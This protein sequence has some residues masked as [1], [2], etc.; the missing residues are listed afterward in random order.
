MPFRIFERLV[1][2]VA[3][4]GTHA[5]R[6][7]GTEVPVAPPP[8]SLAGFYWHFIR[9]A[10]ALFAAL[11]LAGLLVALLDAAIPAMIGR[12][13]ALLTSHAPD[14]LW[15]EAW[16]SLLG[17][18]A[19]VL[20]GRPGAVLLQNLIT[21]QAIN[22]QFHQRWSAGRATGMSSARGWPFFQN[23]F[24]G[25]IA[26][27]VMQSGPAL[28][29]SVVRC[30]NAVWYILVYGS[31]ALLLLAMPTGGWRCPSRCG[32]SP[33]PGCCG[34]LCRGCA[35][36][37]AQCS[38]SALAADRADCGQLHQYPDGEAVRPGGDEDAFVR[39]G[40]SSLT[41]P[42]AGRCGW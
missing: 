19:L 24:A 32:S 29:E 16:P 10:K 40:I 13:V 2:P 39:D 21:K 25:R 3:A 23:D 41:P 11:F 7:F 20:F 15:A 42:S 33:M 30:V 34:C 9:Q 14:R 38:E 36:A 4:P 17:M 22:R 12:L 8:R 35:T 6:L 31:A 5:S 1:D 37:R 18:G 28:R 26:N 27:R